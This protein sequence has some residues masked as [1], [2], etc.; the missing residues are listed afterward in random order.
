MC[1]YVYVC[2]CTHTHIHT[3]NIHTHHVCLSICSSCILGLLSH[4]AIMSNAAINMNAQI[5]LSDPAFDPFGYIPRSRI[6]GSYATSALLYSLEF[7]S[8]FCQLNFIKY[9]CIILDKIF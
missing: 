3:Y 7:S 2:I 4:L 6:A 8:L 9:L 5:C 1:V